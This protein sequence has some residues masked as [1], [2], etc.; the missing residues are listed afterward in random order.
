MKVVLVGCGGISG[1]WLEALKTMPELE[2]VGFIDVVEENARKRQQDY[3]PNALVGTRLESVLTQTKPDIVFDC[4]IPEAHY[5]VVM[6][7][8]EHGCHV[9]GEKPMADN[10]EQA[11]KMIK[12]AQNVGKL[13]AVMQNWRYTHNIRRLK[14]FLSKDLLGTI[15]TINADFYIGAHFGG[16]RDTMPHVLL[17]DMAIHTF[18]A[19]RFLTERNA[20]SVY[21]AEWNPEGSWYNRDASAVAIFEMTG[22]VKFNYRGSWCAEGFRTSWEGEWRIIG[23]RGSLHWDGNAGITCQILEDVKEK[24]FLR[25]LRDVEVP[26]YDDI[27]KRPEGHAA[28]I[29]DFL[30]ALKTNTQPE[31]ICTDNIKSLAMVYGAIES[32]EKGKKVAIRY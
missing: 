5:E 25:S 11:H 28:V 27:P 12:A 4:T 30:K 14:C 1:A 6:T 19:A 16:F 8:L 7:A 9:L 20:T 21:A 23:T 17:K 31:T 15:T 13:F 32:A 3:A 24:T 2:L 10:L 22:N 29:Q 26:F 18:D